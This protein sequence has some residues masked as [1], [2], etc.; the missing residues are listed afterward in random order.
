MN[1]E[2]ALVMVLMG[3]IIVLL[4]YITSIMIDAKRQI[5]EINILQM[6][7]CAILECKL[8]FFGDYSCKTINKG[9][10]LREDNFPM[11]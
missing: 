3:L 1:K 8:T 2:I 10:E 9:P 4:I 6:Q 7:K 11:I 5:S